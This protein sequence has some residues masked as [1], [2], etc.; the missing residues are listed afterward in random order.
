MNNLLIWPIVLPLLATLAVLKFEDRAV[1]VQRHLGPDV[2]M[3]LDE[4]PPHAATKG[5][6]ARAVER[7]LRSTAA[8]RRGRTK[9]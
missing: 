8:G 6:V 5:E 7:A 2:M 3:Q 1:D 4:C 9:I